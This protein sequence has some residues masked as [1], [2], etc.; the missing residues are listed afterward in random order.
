MLALTYLKLLCE[1]IDGVEVIKAFNR[2]EIFLQEIA[3]IDCDVCIMDIQMPGITGLEVASK[4]P[5]IPIV[6]TTAYKEFAADAFDLN[7]VDYVRKPLKKERLEQALRKIKLHKTI[8]EPIFFEWNTSL[9]KVKISADSILLIKTS[10]IDS[11]DK[12]AFLDDFSEL[13]LKNINFKTLLDLLPSE[14]FF[15][16]NKKEIVAKKIIKA[17]SGT[18]IITNISESAGFPLK[19]Q[20]SQAFKEAFE[21][22]MN[23]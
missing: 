11:R 18:T 15:Q 13:I 12:V 5:E 9:G 22:G 17:F 7:V 4:I 23:M 21:K 16:I 3:K 2:P 10:E 20:L 1:Q 19:F 8:T 14:Q 6:F